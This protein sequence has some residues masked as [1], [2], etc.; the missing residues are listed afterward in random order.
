MKIT[1]IN[2]RPSGGSKVACVDGTTVAPGG[3]H[4]MI[5]RTKADVAYQ[6]SVANGNKVIVLAELDGNDRAPIVCEMKNPGDASGV[7]TLAGVGFDLLTEAGAAANVNPTMLLGV[8]D[9]EGCQ[10]PAV[11]ADLDT[12]TTGAIDSGGGTNLVEV[13]PDAT[14][15]FAC[16]VNNTEDETVYLKAWPKESDYIVDSSSLDSVE[17]TA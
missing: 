15:E 9:D 10:T 11:N 4:E 14:G 6:K 7:A 13:T 8:F 2:N 3:S 12:A 16:S 5:G 17:F 1:V